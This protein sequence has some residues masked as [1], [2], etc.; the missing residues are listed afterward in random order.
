M[1]LVFKVSISGFDFNFMY[2][3]LLDFVQVDMYCWKYVNGDWV[4]GGKVEFVVFNCVY[5][6]FDFLNFGVYWMKEIVFFSKVKL[7][8]KFNGGGQVRIFIFI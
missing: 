8:N 2:I 7:I 5:I 6:Y 3:L 1:F 4:V